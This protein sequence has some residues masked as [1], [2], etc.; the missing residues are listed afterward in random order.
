MRKPCKKDYKKK[1]GKREVPL[2]QCGVDE[3]RSGKTGDRT[4]IPSEEKRKGRKR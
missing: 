2:K 3:A 1:E 4:P